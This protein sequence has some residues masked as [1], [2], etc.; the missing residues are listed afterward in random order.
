MSD[1]PLE[2]SPIA[3]L[4]DLDEQIISYKL[5]AEENI[6][7][8]IAMNM[9][10]VSIADNERR[11]YFTLLIYNPHDGSFYSKYQVPPIAEDE[12]KLKQKTEELALENLLKH[13]LVSF[14]IEQ[15][16]TH[17]LDLHKDRKF[18]LLHSLNKDSEKDTEWLESLKS[19]YTRVSM[20][21]LHSLIPYPLDNKLK[22]PSSDIRNFGD[23]A[24]LFLDENSRKPRKSNMLQYPLLLDT[25]TTARQ[26]TGDEILLS[27][28]NSYYHM[29]L[30][31]IEKKVPKYFYDLNFYRIQV[32]IYH[33]HSL[34]G[35]L[36]VG[37]NIEGSDSATEKRRA[38]RVADI[39]KY[40]SGRFG[41]ELRNFWERI[42]SLR[43]SEDK[44]NLVDTVIDLLG[45]TSVSIE[46]ADNSVAYTLSK[47]SNETSF[48]TFKKCDVF[49][50]GHLLD[51]SFPNHKDT[52]INYISP[53]SDFPEALI[54]PFHQKIGL[55]LR[56]LYDQETFEKKNTF[57]H[58]L[59]KSEIGAFISN[60]QYP[61]KEDAVITFLRLILQQYHRSTDNWQI[62]RKSGIVLDLNAICK[63]QPGS[64]ELV[65]CGKSN[66]T[67]EIN[68][69]HNGSKPFILRCKRAFLPNDNIK[70]A[71][72]NIILSEEVK[73]FFMD[74]GLDIFL[75]T[76]NASL[77]EKGDH[78]RYIVIYNTRGVKI[79]FD[80]FA[81][82][83]DNNEGLVRWEDVYS[84]LDL[85]G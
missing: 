20:D 7:T 12:K 34:M 23:I 22:I 29:L 75:L 78:A 64:P 32:P 50:Q 35:V 62:E 77:V 27:E 37:W 76:E 83:F 53:V 21:S 45:A 58:H 46:S 68:I 31:N 49:K 81:E 38:E 11:G 85:G 43:L 18:I 61:T 33:S 54:K 84:T 1:S 66:K 39:L 82:N 60:S 30:D 72:R 55:N 63:R 5:Y 40:E 15:N 79:D 16:I 51:I 44:N 6:V 4:L 25:L 13:P 24:Q 36:I 19:G 69:K 56:S 14:W 74:F 57:D 26:L 10:S 52:T 47:R 42:A 8:P 3:Q 9:E 28:I 70:T 59:Y 48:Q 2:C 80:E 17:I 41:V 71:L 73:E 65:C 67:L